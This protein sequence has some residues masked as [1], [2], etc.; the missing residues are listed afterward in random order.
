M[1]P[2]QSI[3]GQCPFC[4]SGTEIYFAVR[5][6]G[7]QKD[8]EKECR[9][10]AVCSNCG[11]Q[12][13]AFGV[14]SFNNETT[15]AQYWN[16]RACLPAGEVGALE[17]QPLCPVHRK[18]EDAGKLECEIGG[19]NCVA[20]SLNERTE[21]LAILATFTA[22]GNTED[23]VTVLRRVTEFYA[24]HVGEDR[25]IVSYPAATPTPTSE[26]AHESAGM[27]DTEKLGRL[28]TATGQQTLIAALS[29]IQRHRAPS[30]PSSESSDLVGEARQILARTG[31]DYFA[32]VPRKTL[33]AMADE[34]E[35]LR[36][37]I[38]HMHVHSGYRDNG[39]MQMTTPQKELYDA[40]WNRSVAKADE[41]L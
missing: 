26:D 10:V 33:S 18:L 3:D 15:A 28:I 8:R 19:N 14:M 31:S 17:S 11:A 1:K 34:I 35:R 25:V 4:P 27:S 9:I 22:E 30:Q 16:T 13:P 39:Y 12:G 23:S 38:A 6:V 40:I 29:W 37:L 5:E 41:Q 20:C 21:L 24:T 36:D 32:S 7:W 2:K